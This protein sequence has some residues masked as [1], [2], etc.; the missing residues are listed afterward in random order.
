[1]STGVLEPT[2]D[3]FVGTPPLFFSFFSSNSCGK[4][5]GG[6]TVKTYKRSTEQ[7]S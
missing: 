2:F 6:G 4:E 3:G 1:M 7:G 5:G